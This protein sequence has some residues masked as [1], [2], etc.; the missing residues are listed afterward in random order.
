MRLLKLRGKLLKHPLNNRLYGT[1]DLFL[2][3]RIRLFE[4]D[5]VASTHDTRE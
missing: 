2:R 1:G 4:C 5:G 3:R